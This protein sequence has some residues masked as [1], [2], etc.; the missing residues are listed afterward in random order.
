MTNTPML[1]TLYYLLVCVFP[2]H[3]YRYNGYGTFSIPRSAA[4]SVGD[5]FLSHQWQIYY[6]G[7]TTLILSRGVVVNLI[8][9]IPLVPS[10]CVS[11]RA[12]AILQPIRAVVQNQGLS[13]QGCC[14]LNLVQC[15]W[16]YVSMDQV[17]CGIS[18][19][20]IPS[21]EKYKLKLYTVGHP[22]HQQNI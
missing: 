10:P 19:S 5:C 18:I 1:W 2:G 20:N 3:Q 17:R 7:G 14:I 21:E 8:S 12:S 22:L 15:D 6:M 4:C 13:P 11:K 16:D 9:A